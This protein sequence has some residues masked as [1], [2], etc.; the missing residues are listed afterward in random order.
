MRYRAR[1]SFTVE[2]KR[3]NKRLP[4]T[5]PAGDSASYER[6]R[7]ADQLLFGDRSPGV[8][9]AARLDDGGVSTRPTDAARQPPAAEAVRSEPQAEAAVAQR[10]TG[11]ILPDLFGET[12][13]DAR[14]R[15][16]LAERAARLTSLSVE[17]T[18]AD[19]Q[20]RNELDAERKTAPD[21][22]PAAEPLS[23]E[24]PVLATVEGVALAVV[25][26]V[27]KPSL[28]PPDSS[29][30]R[31]GSQRGHRGRRGFQAGRLGSERQGASAG[32]RAG[33]KWKRRL[34]RVCW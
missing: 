31:T 23:L 9:S 27:E 20:A 17:P 2:V 33:E 5:V 25:E 8:S 7:R 3:N 16:L 28:S 29:P 10:P 30:E 22:I 34:P 21:A 24:E 12:R 19:T 32:L 15:Q 26:P 4:L 18:R 11:R 6:C 13:A 14:L 1:P